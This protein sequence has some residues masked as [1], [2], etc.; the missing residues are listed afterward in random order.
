MKI[1]TITCHNV[2]NYGAILQAYALQRFLEDNGHEVEIIDY[3]PRY[4]SNSSWNIPENSSVYKLASKFIVIHLLY[5]LHRFINKIRNVNTSRLKKFDDF[6]AHYLHVT[7]HKYKN[8]EDILRNPPLADMYIAGSDQIWNPIGKTGL[9]PA[10]YLNFGGSGIKRISYAA[11]FGVSQISVNDQSIIKKYISKLDSISVREN[12]G[13]KIL[14]ELGVHN[15]IRV[16]D[17]VFLLGKNAWLS[18]LSTVDKLE[19]TNYILVYD[20]F[21]DDEYIKDMAFK[22]K[23]KFGYKIVSVNDNGMLPYADRNISDASPL[24]FLSLINNAK[25]VVSNSFHATA[26]SIILNKDFYTYPVLRHNNESR[27]IDLLNEFGL[28]ERY[29]SIFICKSIDWEEVFPK[30]KKQLDYSVEFLLK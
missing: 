30:Y 21:Q 29:R 23:K 17:P 1:K 12:T 24:E 2:Y 13:I 15:A 6:T 18:L 3:A 5:A 22:I 26:F 8:Y 27:M 14:K 7:S 9:D 4:H 10:F 25:V 16:L 11:S 19:K 28:I 20:F